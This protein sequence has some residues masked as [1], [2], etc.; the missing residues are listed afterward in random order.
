MADAHITLSQLKGLLQMEG[1]G[2]AANLHVRPV[3]ETAVPHL[4]SSR[5]V[6]AWDKRPSWG[7][8]A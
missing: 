6:H 1:L 7:S 4:I 3:L 8:R 2:P 5:T